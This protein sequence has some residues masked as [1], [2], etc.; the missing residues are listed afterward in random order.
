M[1]LFCYSTIYSNGYYQERARSAIVRVT[2]CQ[3]RRRNSRRL[4]KIGASQRERCAQVCRTQRCYS[5][6]GHWTSAGAALA[7]GKYTAWDASHYIDTWTHTK[8]TEN[9]YS[10]LKTSAGNDMKTKEI[11]WAHQR[12]S[13]LVLTHKGDSAGAEDSSSFLS[14]QCRSF[15]HRMISLLQSS[16]VVYFGR[17]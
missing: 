16:I 17:L 5:S 12:Y 7:C 3:M 8:G 2:A 6:V 13:S 4:R 10:T 9:R 11:A 14:T 15:I 1:T